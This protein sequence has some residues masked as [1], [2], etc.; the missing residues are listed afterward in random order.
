MADSNTTNQA[1]D[2]LQTEDTPPV[3]TGEL[4]E[5]DDGQKQKVRPSESDVYKR[6]QRIRTAVRGTI[7]V[8][9]LGLSEAAL[10]GYRWFYAGTD[11][12]RDGSWHMS[13][14]YD[15]LKAED[16]L[17]RVAPAHLRDLERIED[18]F[19]QAL[20]LEEQVSPHERYL[21]SQPDESTDDSETHGKNDID[22]LE[23]FSTLVKSFHAE[24]EKNPG[25]ID[26]DAKQLYR[27]LHVEVI[28]ALD[29]MMAHTHWNVVP[30]GAP[31]D[32]KN[33]HDDLKKLKAT[34]PGPKKLQATDPSIALDS[35]KD[36]AASTEPVVVKMNEVMTS[37]VKV[38]SSS[39]AEG[40]SA[41]RYARILN[42]I[43][44][45]TQSIVDSQYAEQTRT[46]YLVSDPTKS[47]NPSNRE[48]II[49][50]ERAMQNLEALAKKAIKT[51]RTG[52]RGDRVIGKEDAE[53]LQE[54]LGFLI[55][56]LKAFAKQRHDIA[57]QDGVTRYEAN[58]EDIT[59]LRTEYVAKWIART[60]FLMMG[61]GVGGLLT[62]RFDDG[63]MNFSPNTVAPVAGYHVA[64]GSAELV[65]GYDLPG[66]FT[67]TNTENQADTPRTLIEDFEGMTISIQNNILH[68]EGAE[69]APPFKL[70][71]S[72][73]DGRNGVVQPP[74]TVG[75]DD[76]NNY[77][78]AG[79]IA[80]GK[81]QIAAK[82]ADEFSGWER[83]N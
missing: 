75:L 79:D 52:K 48:K 2:P 3:S 8:L 6:N 13:G 40:E 60:R 25:D 58:P 37:G 4:N 50:I 70:Y 16:E 56:D 1:R 68:V 83:V 67:Y 46:D 10:S 19:E 80:K 23:N 14:K 54:A 44:R 72:I 41:D 71:V 81:V 82:T 61:I 20:D 32:V 7:G 22:T 18:D 65:T 64:V 66:G 43:E 31:D 12:A 53:R 15:R 57:T 9:T 39:V 36:W 21:K 34:L 27:D 11:A 69:D 51:D 47:G 35:M 59:Q 77:N 26:D 49:T 73:S 78:L 38:V 30:D 24:Q 5:S 45:L 62:D 17:T 33:V 76:S 29:S 28:S 55:A 63:K 74:M 42:E